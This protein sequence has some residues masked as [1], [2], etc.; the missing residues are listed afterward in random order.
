MYGFRMDRRGRRRE[1]GS[2][3]VPREGSPAPVTGRPDTAMVSVDG[4][5][6][7]LV[8]PIIV[9]VNIYTQR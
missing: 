3:Q 6:H 5:T 2:W 9:I 1:G 7:P 8:L 4:S